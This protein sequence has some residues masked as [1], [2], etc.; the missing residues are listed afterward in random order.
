MS[1]TSIKEKAVAFEALSM[2][3]KGDSDKAWEVLESLD[4]D[5]SSPFASYTRDF[6]SSQEEENEFNEIWRRVRDA[7]DKEKIPYKILDQDDERVRGRISP[8]HFVYTA[9]NRELGDEKRLVILG[10]PLP[11]LMA[12]SEI[13]D[14]VAFASEKCW[15]ITAPFD[16]GSGSYALSTALKL[17]ALPIAVLPS[18][19]SKCPTQGMLELMEKVYEN[20]ILVTQFAPSLKYEKWHVVLRNRFLSSFGDAF[21]LVE[22][23]D[24]GPSWPV[25]DSA[26]EKGKKTALSFSACTNPNFSWMKTRMKEDVIQYKK[27]RDL[28]KLFPGEKRER[29]KREKYVD[30]TPSLFD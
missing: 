16:L 12:K 29:K 7:F 28:Q 8:S 18:G 10:S 2:F 25:F 19:I 1:E 30:L 5:Y 15:A 11:S 27:S 13:F 4:A 22:E 24:G 9:G 17:G 20:G 14:A 26:Y 3:F 23:K 6:T 21:F